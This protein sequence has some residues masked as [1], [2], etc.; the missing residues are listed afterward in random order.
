MDLMH[1]YSFEPPQMRVLTKIWLPNISLRTDAIFLDITKD[2]WSP[3]L[4]I[5]TALLS[6]Q[7]LLSAAE[8]TDPQD[9]KM[10][11]MCLH[12]Q[13]QFLNTARLL[14]DDYDIQKDTGDDTA[15][16]RFI[17][18]G[19]PRVRMRSLCGETWLGGGSRKK[20]R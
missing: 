9:A 14:A 10:A 19:F 13:K 7:A 17:G 18:T 8:P 3:A 6:M 2:A 1:E 15:S 4:T 16:P 11:K 12:D 20:D 5:K